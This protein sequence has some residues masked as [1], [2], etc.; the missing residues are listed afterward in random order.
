MTDRLI[1]GGYRD[2]VGDIVNAIAETFVMLERWE[3]RGLRAVV[4]EMLLHMPEDHRDDI[5]ASAAKA[6]NEMRRYLT[7]ASYHDEQ[8]ALAVARLEELEGLLAKLDETGTRE[9]LKLARSIA[10]RTAAAAK[11]SG[12][13]A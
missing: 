6:A 10:A 7:D 4:F 3:P 2:G 8:N 5:V 12:G 13:A 11:S 9:M 1:E